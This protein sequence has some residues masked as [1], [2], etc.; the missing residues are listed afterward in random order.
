M[1]SKSEIINRLSIWQKDSL[2]TKIVGDVCAQGL[3]CNQA[4]EIELIFD[5][6]DPDEISADALACKD[7]LA[8]NLSDSAFVYYLPRFLFLIME[9]SDRL[10]VFSDAVVSKLQPVFASDGG[11][12]K[13]WKASIDEALNKHEKKIVADVLVYLK[14]KYNVSLYSDPLELYWQRYIDL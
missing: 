2:Q 9:D 10:D 13:R 4:R 8:L 5:S 12:R 7:Y 14:G 3:N 11:L 1:K 6:R